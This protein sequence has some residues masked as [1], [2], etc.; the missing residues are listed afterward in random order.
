MT[1]YDDESDVMMNM[2]EHLKQRHDDN[3]NQTKV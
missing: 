1:I 3:N 2:I